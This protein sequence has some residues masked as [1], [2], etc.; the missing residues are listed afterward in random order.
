M[1]DF[2]FIPAIDV[3]GGRCVQLAQGKY[4]RVTVF[5]DDPVAVAAR[6]TAHPIRRLHVVDLDGAKDG[7]R[8]NAEVIQRIVEQAGS[9][10]VELGGGLRTIAAIDEALSSGVDRAIL[11]T[12][13]L[14]DPKLVGEASRRFPGQIAV[15]I[16]AKAGRVAVEGWLDESETTA[17]EVARR[18][19]DAGVAAIIYT[20]ITR[21]GMLG[22]PNL[23]ET[24]ALARAVA[25]PVIASGGMSSEQD[26]RRT[27][28]YSD[29]IIAGAIVGTAVYTG[30]V[31]IGRVLEKLSCS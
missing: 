27:A 1:T 5:D 22:G 11:G 12:V 25:L 7:R 6:F 14:R 23:V 30:A 28:S 3:L 15:G 8:R 20:D 10:P 19:E 18:F 2:E 17:I 13:A 31:D 9:V 21:D 24:A 26:V 29:G 4:D 16:D